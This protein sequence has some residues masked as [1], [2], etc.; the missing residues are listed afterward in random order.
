MNNY[1]DFGPEPE[2]L[3]QGKYTPP[4][5]AK[6]LGLTKQGVYHI[7]KNGKPWPLLDECEVAR[8]NR[9]RILSILIPA[10]VLEKIHKR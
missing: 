3:A 4:Q 10:K 2:P 6:M 1:R 7:L 8:D 5:V 9:G